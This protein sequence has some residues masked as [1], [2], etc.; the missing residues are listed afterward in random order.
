[1]G[2]YVVGMHRSGTSA[3]SHAL[4]ILVGYAG[5]AEPEKGNPVGHWENPDLR[6]ELDLLMRSLGSDWSAPPLQPASWN[7]RAAQPHKDAI[8]SVVADLGDGAWV[9]KDPRLCVALDAVLE[10][11]QPPAI[12]VN[13]YRHPVEVASSINARDGLPFMFGLALWEAYVRL[14]LLQG[15]TAST[16]VWVAQ[17]DLMTRTE[18]TIDS[19]ADSLRS[20]GL[21]VSEASVQA[22]AASIDPDL[23]HAASGSADDRAALLSDQQRD[24]LDVVRQ[25]AD[26]DISDNLPEMTPWAEA[27]IELRRPFS[28]LNR[29]YGVLSRR[30]RRLKPAFTTYDWLKDHWRAVRGGD[31]ERR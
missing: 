29:K 23:R 21:S 15:A 4:G 25:R 11:P 28:D 24:L 19:I 14:Q 6:R 20:S 3:L 10:A 31:G 18:A 22:A 8:W 30:M 5:R 17:D 27:M 12:V 7:Q 2:I 13:I 9:L 1:M 26:G 16:V